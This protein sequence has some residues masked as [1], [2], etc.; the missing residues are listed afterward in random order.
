VCAREF[1][2]LS[3]WAA[4]TTSNIEDFV[5]ILDANFCGKVVFVTSNGLVE[6]FTVCESA[7]VERLT[8]AIFVEICSEVVVTINGE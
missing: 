4:D 8:P 3:G 5:S 1:C 6:W 2:D 7:E